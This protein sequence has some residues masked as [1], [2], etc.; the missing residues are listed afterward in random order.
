[1]YIKPFLPCLIGTPF[2]LRKKYQIKQS[3]MGNKKSNR[4]IIASIAYVLLYIYLNLL[5]YKLKIIYLK[6]GSITYII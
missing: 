3:M 2:F 6:I 1:M 4:N 5:I